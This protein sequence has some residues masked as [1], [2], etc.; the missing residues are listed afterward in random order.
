[1]ATTYDPLE[2]KYTPRICVKNVLNIDI[3]RTVGIKYSE[4][5][6]MSFKDSIERAK[7]ALNCEDLHWL[8]EMNIGS[9]T[10]ELM[11]WS[12]YNHFQYRLIFSSF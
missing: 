7:K 2:S 12:R 1:M 6:I 5:W 11:F 3:S 8:S 4:M 10:Q 9:M